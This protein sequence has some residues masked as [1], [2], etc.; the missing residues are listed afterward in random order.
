MATEHEWIDI[1]ARRFEADAWR[2]PSEAEPVVFVWNFPVARVAPRDW[3]CERVREID[4]AV[5]PPPYVPETMPYAPPILSPVPFVTQGL[6]RVP[7]HPDAMLKADVFEC[8]APSHARELLLR[9]LGEF[10]SPLMH[11][12]D[13]GPG[14]VSL[15]GHGE[16]LVLFARGNLVCLCRNAAP[17]IVSVMPIADALDEAVLG[18]K[19]A[20]RASASARPGDGAGEDERVEVVLL[21]PAFERRPGGAF[22]R[23]RAPSGTIRI[24]GDQVVYRGPAGAARR[25]ETEDAL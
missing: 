24:E 6:W 4:G 15:G 7:G 18:G 16:G 23:F 22:R 2:L 10:E 8:A 5:R 13:A 14:D 20:D 3:S 19:A 12:W 9:L 11:R 25:L 17:D 1:V 21:G